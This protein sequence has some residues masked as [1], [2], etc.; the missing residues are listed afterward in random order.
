M[1]NHPGFEIKTIY[2]KS[3]YF[4]KY[5]SYSLT[6][7]EKDNGNLNTINVVEMSENTYRHLK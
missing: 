2:I 1:K 5:I 7:S 6:H 4:L 3:V